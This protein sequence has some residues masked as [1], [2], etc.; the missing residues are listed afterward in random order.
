MAL[1]KTFDTD[2]TRLEFGNVR[3]ALQAKVVQALEKQRGIKCREPSVDRKGCTVYP[4]E[5]EG[6][7]EEDF[8]AFYEF[9]EKL[10]EQTGVSCGPVCDIF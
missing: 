10:G 7:A 2:G 3:P 1:S 6:I 5:G 9:C 4:F 8:D